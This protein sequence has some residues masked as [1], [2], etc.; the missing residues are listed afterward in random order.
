MKSFSCL[1]S[2]ATWRCCLAVCTFVTVWKSGRIRRQTSPSH[3]HI[4]YFLFFILKFVFENECSGIGEK[5]GM[6]EDA[7]TKLEIFDGGSK[8]YI[9]KNFYRTRGSKTYNY[10]LHTFKKFGVGI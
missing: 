9:P 8:T 6:Y 1:E 5:M 2:D 7:V 10:K 3:T 4:I